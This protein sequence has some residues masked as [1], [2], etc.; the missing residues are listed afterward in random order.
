MGLPSNHSSERAACCLSSTITI[1]IGLTSASTDAPYLK[2]PNK[3]PI[4][5]SIMGEAN[6]ILS[7]LRNAVPLRLL[8]PLDADPS[9]SLFC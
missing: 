3:Q 4:E 1:I 6:T 2:D 9:E 8:T 7:L 5:T